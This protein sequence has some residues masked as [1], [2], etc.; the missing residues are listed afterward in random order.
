[1]VTSSPKSA[2]VSRNVLPNFMPIRFKTTE[3]WAFFFRR[4][5]TN[6]DFRLCDTRSVPD[7]NIRYCHLSKLFIATYTVSDLQRLAS[8]DCATIKCRLFHP[9]PVLITKGLLSA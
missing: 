5:R 7:L 9:K 3:P 1:M 6:K 2:S 8:T 4:G